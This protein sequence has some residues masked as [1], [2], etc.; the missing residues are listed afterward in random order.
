MGLRDQPLGTVS[1]SFTLDCRRE[2]FSKIPERY[3]ALLGSLMVAAVCVASIAWNQRSLE[4]DDL[5]LAVY[6]YRV[7][8]FVDL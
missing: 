8:M 6:I 4:A 7:C 2:T 5:R 1:L 3:H